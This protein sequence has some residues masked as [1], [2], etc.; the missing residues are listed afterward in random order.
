MG[1]G[2]T[3]KKKVALFLYEETTLQ[4]FKRGDSRPTF[5]HDLNLLQIMNSW[6]DNENVALMA[7]INRPNLVK[8][9]LTWDDLQEYE[10]LRVKYVD[11]SKSEGL[12]QTYVLSANFL[13]FQFNDFGSSAIRVLL[14]AA[15]HFLEDPLQFYGKHFIDYM[16]VLSH[17]TDL[18]ITQTNR[19][20]QVLSEIVKLISGLDISNRIALF[21]LKT[22]KVPSE[23]LMKRRIQTRARLGIG[24][25][26]LVLVN[27]GG[28]WKWTNFL[29]FLE[30]FT[31][32][33][34]EK[35]WLIQPALG[36]KENDE[37]R[38]YH[39][40]IKD[41]LSLIDPKVRKRIIL[42]DS[43]NL[44]E[45]VLCDFLCASDVGLILERQSLEVW[46]SYRVRMLEYVRHNLIIYSNKGT[47]LDEFVYP[48]DLL[49]ALGDSKDR[50]MADLEKLESMLTEV[51]SQLKPE[52]L[53]YPSLSQFVDVKSNALRGP[54]IVSRILNTNRQAQPR[55]GI[56]ANRV[57]TT[58]ASIKL[59]DKLRM[60]YLQL[61]YW[62]Q[63]FLRPVRRIVK[64]WINK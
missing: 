39:R 43:W 8:E 50:Y 64:N 16:E 30:A 10:K 7:S 49:F 63:I 20:S 34:S 31:E 54:E 29:T 26:D 41:H 42:G 61:P 12:E 56:H 36:Q 45:N 53:R 47:F 48:A 15:V 38:E 5:S 59:S 33:K 55:E 21:N 60:L 14:Q 44:D 19:M 17:K 46:Q 28:A 58:K 32:L 1:S 3:D 27:A 2:E 62:A 35:I 6:V 4:N 40:L 13:A 37:H 24:L 23:E 52:I 51:P 18:I 22:N 11:F 57:S 25:G 9:I